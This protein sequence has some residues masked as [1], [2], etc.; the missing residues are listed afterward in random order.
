MKQLKYIPT[1]KLIEIL[2]SHHCTGIN[3]HDY[4]PYKDELEQ[5]LWERQSR[6]DNEKLIDQY[7][8]PE[9]DNDQAA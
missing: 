8:K 4:G 7:F 9:S 6:Q 5:I 2:D 3:G 1:K